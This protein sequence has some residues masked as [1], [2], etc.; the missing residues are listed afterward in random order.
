M[1]NGSCKKREETLAGLDIKGDVGSGG[2]L[3]I[4]SDPARI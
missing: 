1:S 3:P 2:F 4:S